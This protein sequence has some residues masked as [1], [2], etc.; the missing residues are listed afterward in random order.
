MKT[1]SALWRSVGWRT[2]LPSSHPSLCPLCAYT[3]LVATFFMYWKPDLYKEHS[4][5]VFRMSGQGKGGNLQVAFNNQKYVWWG[6]E[7]KFRWNQISWFSELRDRNICTFL[8]HWTHTPKIPAED[9]SHW[10]SA[11]RF[12]PDFVANIYKVSTENI[13]L[14][15]HQHLFKHKSV[16]SNSERKAVIYTQ[17]YCFTHV[18]TANT[19]TEPRWCNRSVWYSADALCEM[20]FICLFR[21]SKEQ[22]V[23]RLSSQLSPTVTWLR[24]KKL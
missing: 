1:T 10:S 4:I 6:R 2:D 16:Q 21:S 19:C 15:I 9:H 20:R 12:T 24:S 7:R 14:N 23:G 18:V 22:N 11:L 13:C 17:F 8:H 5:S 3:I